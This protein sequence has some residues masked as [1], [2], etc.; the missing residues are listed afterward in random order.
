MDHAVSEDIVLRNF[1]TNPF[2][3]LSAVFALTGFFALFSFLTQDWTWFSRSGGLVLIVGGV[4]ATRRI[5]RSGIEETLQGEYHI[6]G[7]EAGTVI[8]ELDSYKN[9]KAD[10]IAAK[11]AFF[12]LPLGTV[13]NCFGDLIGK[14]YL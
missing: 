9:D 13:I 4:M 12:V 14:L 8:E 2:V 3:L 7:G 10:L 6:S 1:A 11:M 5:I